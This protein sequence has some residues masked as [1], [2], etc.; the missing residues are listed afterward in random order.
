MNLVIYVLIAVIVLLATFAVIHLRTQ[1]KVVNRLM[2]VNK[3]LILLT[4]GKEAKPEALRALVASEKPP[5]GNLKGI[6]TG[7]KKEKKKP[8]NIDY[9]LT[10]GETHG[11]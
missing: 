9:T 7:G 5:Q 4:A 1:L 6:A 11:V 10:V 3:Q 2:E 8:T